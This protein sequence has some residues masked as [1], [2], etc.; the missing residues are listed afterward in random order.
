MNPAEQYILDQ[1]P[2]YRV[3]L[4]HLQV[5]IEHNVTGVTLQYK[6]NVP[7]YYLKGKPFCYLNVN[8]KKQFADLGFW[9]AG[10]LKLHPEHLVTENR[11]MIRSLRYRQLEEV[12]NTVLIDLLN[13]AKMLY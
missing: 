11:K 1:P 4:L 9:K 12:N 2:P 3:I 13:E 8:R 5:I 6:Y 7:F 10:E